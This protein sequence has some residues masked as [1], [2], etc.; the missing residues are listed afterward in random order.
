M[1]TVVGVGVGVGTGVGVGIGVGVGGGVGVGT[2]EGVGVA[3]G[4]A[5]K[6][7]CRPAANLASKSCSA[8]TATVAGI[9]GVAVTTRVTSTT[10][11]GLSGVAVTTIGIGVAGCPHPTSPVKTSAAS[12]TTAAK[13]LLNCNGKTP[14]RQV[15][16]PGAARRVSPNH[17]AAA[18][19]PIIP[20]RP[21]ASDLPGIRS[22]LPSALA[23]R[24]ANPVGSHRQDTPKQTR[25]N[26]CPYQHTRL[27]QCIIS[28]GALPG[29]AL[30]S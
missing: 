23:S 6:V 17:A 20:R 2:G 12:K 15:G 3:V 26:P 27:R 16:L 28:S 29:V 21:R 4:I 19:S 5:T 18:L 11:C 1:G 9:S 25:I 30:E 13:P 14:L 7:A 8:S 10:G 24:P 22:R